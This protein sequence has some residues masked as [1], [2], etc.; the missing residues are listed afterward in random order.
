V[1][2]TYLHGWLAADAA[3]AAWLRAAGAVCA[4]RDHAREVERALDALA[5]HLEAHCD[6]AALI[7]LAR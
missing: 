6:V 5:A 3:R 1:A 2:G 4:P 7:S